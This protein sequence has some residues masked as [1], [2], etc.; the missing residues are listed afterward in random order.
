MVAWKL[1]EQKRQH[2]ERAQPLHRAKLGLLE[3]HA[4]YVKRARDFHSKE[5]RLTKLREKASAKNKDEFYF[6][7]IRSKTLKGV[8]VQSRGNEAMSNDLV[9]VLK[10]QDA[11]YIRTQ[12]A[13]EQGR[14]RRLQQQL[15]SLV[16]NVTN[17][18]PKPTTGADDH[19]EMMR[20]LDDWDAF[21][22]VPP[23]A[24]TSSLGAASGPKKHIIFSD[25]LDK[26]RTVDDPSKILPKKRRT[27]STSTMTKSASSKKGKGKAPTT[28]FGPTPEELEAMNKATQ[29]H[30]ERLTLELDARQERLRQFAL[31]LKELENQRLLMGKGAKKMIVKKKKDP[32]ARVEE[33]W[34]GDKTTMDEEEVG[35]ASGARLY[36]W[37]AQRKR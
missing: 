30:R 17:A 3:K 20:D 5:D 25:D 6:G 26:V 4:D 7:M 21:D 13:M 10:T 35:I 31:A 37:K 32:S 19:D 36:K 14:V 28:E 16:D 23:V 27:P 12:Q 15:D 11:G 2:R 33:D 22:L 1:N 9:K 29:A 18:P 24:S 8:H 34:K